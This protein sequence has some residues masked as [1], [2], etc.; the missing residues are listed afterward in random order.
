MKKLLFMLVLGCLPVM[1]ME[2]NK[3]SVRKEA[4]ARIGEFQPP[5]QGSKIELELR[6][7]A[8]VKG[9][10]SKMVADKIYLD[11]E[12]G[13]TNVYKPEQLAT[14]TK[15]KFFKAEYDKRLKAEIDEITE[16]K[17]VEAEVKEKK[18]AAL[19]V[20]ADEKKDAQKQTVTPKVEEKKT[21][22]SIKKEFGEFKLPDKDSVF[23]LELSDGTKIAGK[24]NKLSGNKVYL[25]VEEGRV[26]VYKRE[27]IS[28][29][30]RWKLFKEDF[31]KKLKESIDEFKAE[32]A[33]KAPP[34]T[35]PAAASASA[36]AA[37]SASA[38]AVTPATPPVAVVP[39]APVPPAAPVASAPASAGTAIPAKPAASAAPSA[40][41]AAP[42]T[43]PAPAPLSTTPVA[44]AKKAI[45]KVENKKS[46]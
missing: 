18:A 38:P 1:A 45:D 43:V 5:E 40:V 9:T 8:K 36:P 11:V 2:I 31:D 37:A 6:D 39:S 32:E 34:V 41:S 19:A 23:E 24:I 10:L 46:E 42:S 33:K 28:P 21:V 16:D 12:D 35:A 13:A 25:E 27:K 30:S 20:K 3:E 14:G 44:A 15:W 17:R 4:V 22:D 26:S 7:G 29:N